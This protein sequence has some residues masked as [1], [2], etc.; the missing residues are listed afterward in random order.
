MQTLST[1]IGSLMEENEKREKELELRASA[2]KSVVVD[3]EQLKQSQAG[4]VSAMG[5]LEL[6]QSRFTQD[7]SRKVT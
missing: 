6:K 1:Q 4:L 2:L 5:S 3:I 7:I